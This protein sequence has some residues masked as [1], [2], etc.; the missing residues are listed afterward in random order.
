[1]KKLLTVFLLLSFSVSLQAQLAK[2]SWGFG[3]GFN[4]PRLI[5]TNVAVSNASYGGFVGIER[6]FSEHVGARFQVKYSHLAYNW[7]A[8]LANDG[9]TNAIAGTFD[10]LYKFVPCEVVTPY[11]A[12]GFGGIYMMHDNPPNPAADDEFDSQFNIGMGADY[13]IDE[14]WKFNVELGYHTVTNGA[15]D[16]LQGN[17]GG[18]G[19]VGGNNDTYMSLNV[20]L[21][22]MFDVGEP[23]KLCQLYDGI[24]VDYDPIDYERVENLIKKHIP[25]EV[26]KE[27]VVEKPVMKEAKWI[28]VGVNFDFNSAKLKSEA[29]P[30]LF[31]AVQVLL[32]NPDLK[33]EIAGHTDNIGS[34]STNQKL[35]VK[36]A[37]VVKNYLVARGV[38]AS[39]LTVKGYGE[40]QP[41]ADNKK[42]SGRAMNRRIE[43]K[44]LN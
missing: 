3:F 40:S 36:R 35:S 16:G 10:L 27:V 14:D 15:L 1:M 21:T 42:A 38:N 41:V 22:Y 43:F 13:G 6:Y 17:S 33:V 44:V 7:G 5:E 12:V 25:R 23:S 30:V 8:G 9:S 2:D 31:H 32:Q 19:L 29:Y 39:R 34:E 4:Y 26:V 11:L 28:L 24:K 37:E 20:G 18:G